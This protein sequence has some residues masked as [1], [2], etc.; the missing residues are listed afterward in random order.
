MHQWSTNVIFKGFCPSQSGLP[1]EPGEC[2]PPGE[3]H[4]PVR[5]PQ[6]PWAEPLQGLLGSFS[7][8]GSPLE[9]KSKCTLLSSRDTRC[10]T[11]SFSENKPKGNCRSLTTKEDGPKLLKSRH[12]SHRILHR[13]VWYLRPPHKCLLRWHKPPPA[14]EVTMVMNTLVIFN[15]ASHFPIHKGYTPFPVQARRGNVS[16]HSPESSLLAQMFLPL[17]RGFLFS[18]LLWSVIPQIPTILFFLNYNHKL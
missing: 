4:E 12:A 11:L 3:P 6:G 8:K 16:R 2:S 5:A 1:R 14:R 7:R 10:H 17:L 13:Q 15:R 9:T 18:S